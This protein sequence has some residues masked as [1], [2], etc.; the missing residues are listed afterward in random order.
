M[1]A[2]KVLVEF[3]PMGEA[4]MTQMAATNYRFRKGDVS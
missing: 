1:D 3:T 4:L 2:R